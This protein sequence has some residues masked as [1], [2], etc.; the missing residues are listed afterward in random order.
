MIGSPTDPVFALISSSGGTIAITAGPGQLNLDLLPPVLVPFGGTSRTVLTSFGVLI[1]EGSSAIHAAVGTNGQ[2]LI[3][4]PTDPVFGLISSSAG[5]LAI[6]AGPGLLNI[7]LLA[8]ISVPFGGTSRTVLTSF[9]VLIGEGS[10]AVH[11]AVG[12]NGQILIGSPTDPVFGL[13]SS[14]AGTLAITAGPGLLNI[15]LLAPISVPFGG[16]GRTALTT[17]G[18]LLGEGSAGVHVT[19]AGTN[20]QVLIGTPTDPV[21]AS[22][23]S[24][25]GTITLIA[26]PGQLNIDLTA[27]VS[28]PFGGTGRTVLTT[29][30]VLLGEGSAGVHVT[31]AGTNG[32]ILLGTPTDPVFGYISSSAGT[33]TLVAGPGQLNIDLTAP[34]SVPF[35]GTGRTVLTTFGVLLGEGSAG[36]HVTAAGT[37][38]QVLLGTPTDPVFGSIT[39]SGGTIT[40]IA[41]PGQLNIDLTAPISVPFGGTGRTVLTTFGVLLGEGSAGVHVTAAGTNGQ[42]L[43][44]T[45]TDP[46][47]G[48]ITSSAGTVILTAGPGQLNVDLKAPVSIAFGGTNTTTFGATISSVVYFD[49]NK[50]NTVTAGTSGFVLKST[51]FGTAPSFQASEP[52]TVLAGSGTTTMASNNG[53]IISGGTVNLALPSTSLVGDILEVALG[54]TVSWTITQIAGQQIRYG[55][56]QTTLGAGGFLASTASGDA[57]RMVCDIASLHWQVLSSTGNLTVN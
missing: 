9:G 13:I 56:I 55:D 46:V 40:L 30:G 22:I 31:A 4:T 41:G 18:V 10:N 53:Y 5:T 28:V 39:S 7:D 43:L 17:F 11:A 35:G 1:G 38:G 29:F 32:Q 52:W 33:V 24:S 54:A 3:G 12:T 15:D 34:V 51:G 49:G 23:T 42:I 20:G 27:P 16:T 50:L 19:A 48:Y 21:F 45:P 37:N 57:V 14:S 36:V 47:F 44:G 2:I 25:G 6:T 8:P 26:G